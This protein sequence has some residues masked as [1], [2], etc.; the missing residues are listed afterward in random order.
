MIGFT[1]EAGIASAFALVG[2]TIGGS[3]RRLLNSR[4]I[5]PASGLSDRQLN[6]IG[7]TAADFRWAARQ[8]LHID[9]AAGELAR[10][11]CERSLGRG[12]RTS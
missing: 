8:P 12:Q 2:W 3:I 10:V 7:L 9:A 4:S 5:C 11:V 6:D 1:D